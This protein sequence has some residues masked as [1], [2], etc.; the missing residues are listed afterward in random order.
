LLNFE[1]K[2][3]SGL[4]TPAKLQMLR[5]RSHGLF[6]NLSD[7]FSRAF[8]PSHYK[9]CP[10]LILCHDYTPVFWHFPGQKYLTL[11]ATS[12]QTNCCT[13]VIDKCCR[14]FCLTFR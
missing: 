1:E 3:G 4:Y 8:A 9:S 10:Q 11:V 7:C 6:R 2:I 13:F 14:R 12:R 5:K